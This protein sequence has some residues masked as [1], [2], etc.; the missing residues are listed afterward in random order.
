MAMTGNAGG[1]GGGDCRLDAID[2]DGDQD[3]AV[4][5]LGDVVLDRVILRARHIVGVEDDQLGAGG[6]C[7]L[8]RAFVDLVEEQGLLIDVDERE[9]VGKRRTRREAYGDG[10]RAA[11]EKSGQTH[12]G[13][14]YLRPTWS[15]CSHGATGTSNHSRDLNGCQ[16]DLKAAASHQNVAGVLTQKMLARS[17]PMLR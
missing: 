17:S 6:V 14:P 15:G 12:C 13:S 7:R 2:V 10:C 5:L 11:G 3:D 8:L 4:D 1:L 16:C 9:G